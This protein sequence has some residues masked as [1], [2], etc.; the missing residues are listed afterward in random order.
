[1][2]KIISSLALCG[3]V[4]L[5]A[6]LPARAEV[7]ISQLR[8]HDTYAKEPQLNMSDFVVGRVRGVTGGIMSVSFYEPVTVGNREVSRVNVS[9][10]AAAGDDV[11]FQVIDDQ[12][13][14]YGPAHPT[15]IS[16]LKIKPES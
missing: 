4:A 12:L 7:L 3:A 14:Y 10:G 2:F 16:R 9:G 1:M 13:V 6:A 8:G 11:L 15:W 5:S